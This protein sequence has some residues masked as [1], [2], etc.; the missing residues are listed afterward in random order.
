M[1]IGRLTK[2]DKS[3]G[4]GFVE[5]DSEMGIST[6][7]HISRLHLGGIRNP[8]VGDV[9]VYEVGEHNGKLCVVSCEPLK[10]RKRVDTDD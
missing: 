2:F 5:P 9:L 10:P 7:C 1:P 3:R 8:E 6:F 4:F